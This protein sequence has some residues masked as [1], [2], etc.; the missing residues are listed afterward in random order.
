MID[1][2]DPSIATWSG[3]GLAFVVKD[4][5]KFAA[6]LSTPDVDAHKLWLRREPLRS[7]STRGRRSLRAVLRGH[8]TAA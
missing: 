5:E 4:I 3:D 7:E 8:G 1:T 6:V 2:C